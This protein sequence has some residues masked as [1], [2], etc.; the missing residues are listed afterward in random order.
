MHIFYVCCDISTKQIATLFGMCLATV[1]NIVYTWA[2]VLCVTLLEIFP[3]PTRSQFFHAYPKS[4]IKKFDRKNIYKLLN[5]NEIGVEVALM[6]TVNA[7]LYR[8]VSG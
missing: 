5:A 8:P 3:A 6:K 2:N 7:V 1:H 4:V